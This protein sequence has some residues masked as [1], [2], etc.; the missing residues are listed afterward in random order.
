MI[1]DYFREFGKIILFG[2]GWKPVS[3]VDIRAKAAFTL[4]LCGCNLK[5][6]FCHNYRLADSDPSLCGKVDMERLLEELDFSRKLVDYFL[7]TGG[8][9]LLQFN[10][11]K[12]LLKIVKEHFKLDV[13]VNSNLTLTY[14]VKSLL[15][16][17]L[18]DF[19]VTDLKIPHLQLYG[20]D[21]GSSDRMW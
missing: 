11:L 4:W 5:C 20:L 10:E 2:A 21:E 7:V 19:I 14:A 9:P 13:A 16:N 12:K 18:C 15:D 17:G 1:Q 3:L 6:T 8:E